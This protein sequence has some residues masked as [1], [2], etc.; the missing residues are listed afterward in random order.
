[1]RY[2]AIRRQ[3][4]SAIRQAQAQ[5]LIHGTSGNI[6]VRQPGEDAVAITPSGR[7]Y[8]TM[9]P[10]DIAIVTLAGEWVDGP[11]RPSSE[12]PMHTA[13]YRARPDV[14]ATVHTHALY[15]TVMAM[16]LE[17]LPPSTPPQAEFAPIRVVPFAVPGSQELAD[18]V[19]GALGSDGLVVLLRNHGNFCCGRDIDAAMTAAAYVEE[20]AQVAYHAALLGQFHPLAE[21][22]IQ[23]CKAILAAGRAV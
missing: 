11:Y 12:T 13:V 17:E 2:E 5:G 15:S 1:M 6:A 4:L 22:D 9:Q 20:A 3:V 8:D 10:E 19:A 14:G 16:G 7:P 23:A 21:K 18:Y